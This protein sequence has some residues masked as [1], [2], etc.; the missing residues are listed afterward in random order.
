MPRTTD[1]RITSALSRV[2]KQTCELLVGLRRE[3]RSKR[4]TFDA[5]RKKNHNSQPYGPV[6]DR[7]S[8]AGFRW[9][10]RCDG[11]HQL[12]HSAGAAV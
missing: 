2:Q 12:G 9:C 4:L 5:S 3:L 10:C 6:G 11:P 8:Q 1:A 7:R